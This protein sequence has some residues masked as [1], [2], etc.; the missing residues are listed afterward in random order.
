MISEIGKRNGDFIILSSN[1]FTFLE[2]MKK[3]INNCL[4]KGTII[5]LR[6]KLDS[7][8]NYKTQKDHL[9]DEGLEVVKRFN[10]YQEI[11]KFAPGHPIN[12][13]I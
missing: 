13:F 9:I 8:K 7:I 5:R 4:I 11:K 2:K 12:N 3:E 6:L 10:K 1:L